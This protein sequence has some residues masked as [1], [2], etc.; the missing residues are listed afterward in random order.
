[1]Y[2]LLQVDR[3]VVQAAIPPAI[4]SVKEQT[5]KDVQVKLDEEN[6]LPTDW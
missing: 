2:F 5:K 3:A 1:L 4:A 6:F